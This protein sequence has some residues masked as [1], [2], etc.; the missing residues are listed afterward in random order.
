MNGGGNSA[1]NQENDGDGDKNGI[2]GDVYDSLYLFA[3]VNYTQVRN[4]S[5]I[6]MRSILS[7]RVNQF[8]HLHR[9]I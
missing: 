9:H 3:C 4:K 2:P 7:Y 1:P 6:I 8:L 5:K